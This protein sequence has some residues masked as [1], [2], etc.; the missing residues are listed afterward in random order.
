METKQTQIFE[1]AT[2]GTVT[3]NAPAKAAPDALIVPIIFNPKDKDGWMKQLKKIQSPWAQTALKKMERLSF[4]AKKKSTFSFDHEGIS[5]TVLAFWSQGSTFETLGWARGC[6]EEL[7]GSKAKRIGLD[8]SFVTDFKGPWLDALVSA[9][10][11]AQYKGPKYGKKA[12]PPTPKV[13]DITAPKK[14]ARQITSMVDG[15]FQSARATNGLRYLTEMAG[16]D[17]TPTALR[18]IAMGFGKLPST[19]TQFFGKKELEKMGAGAFLAVVRGTEEPGVGIV[20]VSYKPAKFLASKRVALVGKGVTYDTG[21]YN[22]KTEGHMLGMHGD[23]GGSA[24]VLATIWLAATCKWPI[25]IEG[26]V[27]VAENVIAPHAY[28]PND[29]VTAMNGKSIEVIDTDAEGRMLL[30][31]AL[32]FAAKDKPALIMDFATLTGAC[33]RAIGT[34]YS[35]VF[36]NK[37]AYFSK[38]IRAGRES[39]E[40]VWPFPNDNDYGDCLKSKIADIKQCRAERG[41]DHIEASYFLKQFVDNVPWVHVD[42]SSCENEGGLAHVPGKVNGFGVRFTRRFL[43]TALELKRAL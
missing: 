38:L 21:G 6:I 5:R 19:K 32:A 26:Y 18:E 35:G 37:S 29:V 12:K 16:N 27:T 9:F 24:T 23:M 28:R 2:P 7:E 3:V 22:V 1:L 40:R 4:K 20:K 17:L 43:E 39:G 11:V 15:A 41:S 8:L 25:A 31:D 30:S 42:L 36:S 33:V 14:N 13:L 34:A 10:T